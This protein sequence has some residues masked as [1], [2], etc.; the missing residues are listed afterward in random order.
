[1]G[2]NLAT[3]TSLLVIAVAMQTAAAVASVVALL[4]LEDPTLMWAGILRT[5]YLDRTENTAQTGTDLQDHRVVGNMD[6]GLEIGSEELGGNFLCKTS[7]FKHR[8]ESSE[9]K[10]PEGV[11]VIQ[12]TRTV[13]GGIYQA[14]L[15]RQGV[16]V[17]LVMPTNHL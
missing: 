16:T 7:S 1:M 2:G 13:G 10:A 6:Q 8:A 12:E 4:V 14:K 3:E 15:W 5:H 9:L 11:D 17:M